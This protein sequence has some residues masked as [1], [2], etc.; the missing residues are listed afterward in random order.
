MFDI[1][2][3]FGLSRWALFILFRQLKQT[4]IHKSQ[5]TIKNIKFKIMNQST[6]KFKQTGIGLIPWDLIFRRL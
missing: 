4:A 1:F 6:E 5:A 3:Y 2:I